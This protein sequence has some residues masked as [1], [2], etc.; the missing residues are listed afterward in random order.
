[1][2]RISDLFKSIEFV[3]SDFNFY[4]INKYLIFEFIINL[5]NLFIK[6]VI[7]NILKLTNFKDHE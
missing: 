3:I 7:P 5:D 2:R 4:Y 1:M 6:D